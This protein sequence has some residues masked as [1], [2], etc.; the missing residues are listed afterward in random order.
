MA[1]HLFATR[2]AVVSAPECE[3]K[4]EESYSDNS[5]RITMGHNTG[6]VDATELLEAVTAM[7]EAIGVLSVKEASG[8]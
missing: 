8:E 3:I 6:V 7:A 1:W 2:Y 5:L 4:I